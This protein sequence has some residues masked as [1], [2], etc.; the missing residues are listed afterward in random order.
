MGGGLFA[1]VKIVAERLTII[2]ADAIFAYSK[3]RCAGEVTEGIPQRAAGRC[4]AAEEFRE[5]HPQAAG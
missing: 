2:L 3:M 1:V 5:I 4:D